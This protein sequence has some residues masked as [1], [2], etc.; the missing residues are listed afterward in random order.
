MRL[1]ILFL[2][3]LGMGCHPVVDVNYPIVERPSFVYKQTSPTEFLALLRTPQALSLVL[4][5]IGCGSKYICRTGV[6]G[7]AYSIQVTPK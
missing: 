6:F 5:E 1:L 2:S 3:L 4:K 7:T